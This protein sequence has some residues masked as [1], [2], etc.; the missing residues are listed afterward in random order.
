[1]SADS[2]WKLAERMAEDEVLHKD[3]LVSKLGYD[4]DIPEEVQTS[5][6]ILLAKHIITELETEPALYST[7]PQLCLMT[8]N[9]RVD[10]YNEC[11]S[12]DPNAPNWQNT[13]FLQ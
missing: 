5:L 11:L 9:I 1:M 2:I 12:L 3:Y 4:I 6:D 13:L 8:K 7:W 10:D